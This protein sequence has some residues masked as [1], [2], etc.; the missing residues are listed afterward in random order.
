MYPSLTT[1][2]DSYAR[3]LKRGAQPMPF[4]EFVTM[5]TSRR[6]QAAQMSSPAAI[7]PRMAGALLD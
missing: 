3:A 6:R 1:D 5:M 7:V 4:P 2:Y